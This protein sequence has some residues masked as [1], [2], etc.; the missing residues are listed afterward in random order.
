[1]KELIEIYENKISAIQRIIYLKDPI[2]PSQRIK[3]RLRC[4]SEFVRQ[5]E[6]K[7]KNK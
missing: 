3:E 4:Y 5:M 2:K 1:M 7:L 6:N